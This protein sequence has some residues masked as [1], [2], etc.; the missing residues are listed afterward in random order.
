[1]SDG[2][3]GFWI[4]IVNQA[5]VLQRTTNGLLEYQWFFLAASSL[6]FPFQH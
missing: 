4:D 6:L 1:M 3:I 5:K 2:I